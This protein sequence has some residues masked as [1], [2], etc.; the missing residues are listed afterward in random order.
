[1]LCMLVLYT[2]ATEE[3]EM[4]KI[5][6]EVRDLIEGRNFAHVATVNPDGSPHVTPVWVGIDGDTLVITTA[7]GRAWPENLRRDP[8]VAVSIHDQENPYSSA[9]IRGT[10][11]IE[12]DT[13]NAQSNLAAQKYTDADTYPVK[14]G[15]RRMVVWVEPDRA[16]YS[17]P[18]Q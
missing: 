16:T 14:D 12:P 13:G 17:P 10:T 2:R 8:R 1:M 18:G 7:E 5:P 11:R 15:E 6:D 9:R 3:A 4:G